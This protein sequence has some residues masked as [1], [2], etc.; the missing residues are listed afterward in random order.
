VAPPRSVIDAR[1]LEHVSSGG[2]SGVPE[3]H[4]LA[5]AN[6]VAGSAPASLRRKSPDAH[7]DER[8]FGRVL[9]R[10]A[11]EQSAG[12]A[13]FG[14]QAGREIDGGLDLSTSHRNAL[15]VEPERDAET[16]AVRNQLKSRR[17]RFLE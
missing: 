1:R 6:A 10:Q 7:A 2:E 5:A 14:L 12:A 11:P 3:A 8:A 17:E 13:E 15:D 16:S 4:G 9:N